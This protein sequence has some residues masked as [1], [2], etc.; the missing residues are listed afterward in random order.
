MPFCS[1]HRQ[2]ASLV[3]QQDADWSDT[4]LCYSGVEPGPCRVSG[5]EKDPGD[6][7]VDRRR[8]APGAH[9]Y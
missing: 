7:G 2:H 1:A 4:Q 8:G 9:T 6:G 3:T 5:K